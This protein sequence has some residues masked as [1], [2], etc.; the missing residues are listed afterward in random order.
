MSELITTIGPGDLGWIIS[1]HGRIY[2]R[3]F[4]FNSDFEVDIA[5]KAVSIVKKQDAFTRIWVKKVK[6]ANAGSVAVSRNK[7]G[8]A[9]IDFLLVLE[10]YRK[11]GIA[12]ELMGTAVHHARTSGFPCVQLET[13]SC[14]KNARKLY[15][16][17]GFQMIRKNRKSNLYGRQADQEFW[18]LVL[19]QPG[20]YRLSL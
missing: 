4:Q 13:Y 8:I 14:L 5:G 6:K 9:F 12:R 19:Q 11:N 20:E 16:D 15:A 3:E 17:L 1:S 7:E 18:E 10:P 2:S